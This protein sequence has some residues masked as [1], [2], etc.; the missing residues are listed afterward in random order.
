MIRP[1]AIRV[2]LTTCMCFAVR[3]LYII[4]GPLML[5]GVRQLSAGV[6]EMD[7]VFW[8]G[9]EV[10]TINTIGAMANV[11]YLVNIVFD[12]LSWAGSDVS[13]VQL[14][15]TGLPFDLMSA[16]LHCYY[17]YVTIIGPVRWSEAYKRRYADEASLVSAFSKPRDGDAF[18][19]EPHT[20]HLS[21][22]SWG[23]IRAM[24]NPDC[25][26]LLRKHAQRL[27]CGEYIAFWDD[28]EQHQLQLK[29]QRQAG[30]VLEGEEDFFQRIFAK[31]IR[32][33]APYAVNVSDA[34]RR[35]YAAAAVAA[36]RLPS[37]G[38]AA[39]SSP[40]GTSS[41]PQTAVLSPGGRVSYASSTAWIEKTD[42]AAETVLRSSLSTEP[43]L[44]PAQPSRNPSPP[45]SSASVAPL[46][47]ASH[48]GAVT[49]RHG[50]TSARLTAKA[51]EETSELSVLHL[52]VY[53][54]V[55][56]LMETNILSDFK[57]SAAFHDFVEH[58]LVP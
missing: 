7:D 24:R 29:G 19:I 51:S 58:Y 46:P 12:A 15:L 52:Q 5:L 40:A 38:S 43:M 33:D 8:Y 49:S 56:Q 13:R 23:L 39:F 4:V 28:C 53:H 35:A 34:L 22:S 21:P 26:L 6:Q 32:V 20:N 36:S 31:Y 10:R 2:V 27:M 16:A 18:T 1:L 57:R 11:Y 44:T 37:D 25:Y 30:A 9:F 54:E 50:S 14:E 41:R 42:N 47:T 3:Y 48:L 55:L 17:F 45:R